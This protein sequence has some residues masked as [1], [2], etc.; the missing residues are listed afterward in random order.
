MSSLPTPHELVQR[1]RR[2]AKKSL[3]QH[4]LL[5]T[6]VLSQMVYAAGVGSGDSV[7]EIGP[8]PGV[9]TQA[10]LAEGAHVTAVELDRD[11]V[12]FLRVQFLNHP[13]EVI[14]QDVLT[15]QLPNDA[16]GWVVLGNLPYNI[17][18]EVFFHLLGFRHQ[19]RCMVLMFQREVAKRFVAEPR[20]KAYGVLSLMG[21]YYFDMT[22]VATVPPGAFRPAPKVHSGVVCFTP[23]PAPLS[24]ALTP[25][26][27]NVVKTAFS[28]RRK[29]LPNALNGV[30]GL[31]KAALNETLERLE[32]STRARPEELTLDAF[33]SLT[34]ALVS[35]AEQSKEDQGHGS[36]P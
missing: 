16:E 3:G 8:G 28:K 31:D 14:E 2:R 20:T 9:L 12:P 34:K 24:D 15:Y 13:L 11:A 33:C 17:A 32:M 36:E 5:D 7:L 4:F 26:F 22:Y 21:Q 29:T 10:I 23:R 27:R 18:T 30:F 25:A 35:L 1:F 19:L 6:S